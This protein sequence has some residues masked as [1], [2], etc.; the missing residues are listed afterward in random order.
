MIGHRCACY[1]CPILNIHLPS[2]DKQRCKWKRIWLW[3]YYS[4]SSATCLY[5]FIFRNTLFG[6]IPFQNR[7][8]LTKSCLFYNVHNLCIFNISQCKKKTNVLIIFYNEGT[9]VQVLTCGKAASD[10]Q[11]VTFIHVSLFSTNSTT[12]IQQNNVASEYCCKTARNTLI[13]TWI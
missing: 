13:W 2:K 6:P 3:I 4:N 11:W 5:W 8:F 12:V 9:S 1:W 10:V 7:N